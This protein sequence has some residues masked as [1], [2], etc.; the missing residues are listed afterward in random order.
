MNF[1]ELR[2]DDDYLAENDFVIDFNHTISTKVHNE[3]LGS[4]RYSPLKKEHEWGP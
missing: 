3:N 2:E 1:D 4:M